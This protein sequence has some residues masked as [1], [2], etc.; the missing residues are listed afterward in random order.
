MQK[1]LDFSSLNTPITF[2][3]ELL[4]VGNAMNI[5]SGI[6]T[7]P[8]SGRY[9]FTLSGIKDG[10]ATGIY[11]SLRLNGAHA[12]QA[13]GSYGGVYYTY[14]MQTTLNMQVG[15]QVSLVVTDGALH[16]NSITSY[17]TN[18]SGW[19]LEEDVFH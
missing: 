8:R 11:I 5:S 1:N 6:F 4:N 18:F 7:A 10:A 15:D 12:G 2:E 19:L 17:F 9:F 13:Y 3:N 16:D 14:S